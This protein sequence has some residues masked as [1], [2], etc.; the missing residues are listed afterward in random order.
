MEGRERE[1][2]DGKSVHV[3]SN[4]GRAQWIATAYTLQHMQCAMYHHYNYTG[5]AR[6]CELQ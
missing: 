5:T 2:F 6:S 1:K 4:Y 3:T